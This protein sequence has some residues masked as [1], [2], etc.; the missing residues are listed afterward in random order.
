MSHS[1]NYRD[2][3]CSVTPKQI[4]KDLSQWAFDPQETSGYHGNLKF[5]DDKV[6]KN[7]D[8]AY[9]WLQKNCINAYDDKAVFYKKGRKK[10]RLCKI[11]YHC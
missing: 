8:E 5:Y 6:F 2:Y 10:Y 7:R 9:D 3:H 11:E 1:I 4:L